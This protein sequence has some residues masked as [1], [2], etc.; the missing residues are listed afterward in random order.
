MKLDD[1][2]LGKKYMDRKLGTVLIC[3]SHPHD[4]ACLIVELCNDPDVVLDL[5]TTEAY[6]LL[7]EVEE[8]ERD[9]VQP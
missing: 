7:Y 3:G 8:K 6:C 9:D 2:K 4:G 5:D 1:V